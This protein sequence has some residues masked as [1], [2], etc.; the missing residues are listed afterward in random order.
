MTPEQKEPEYRIT[1]SQ[2]EIF[3]RMIPTGY[4]NVVNRVRSRPLTSAP[5]NKPQSPCLHYGV[6]YFVRKG[7]CL[8]NDGEDCDHVLPSAQDTTGQCENCKNKGKRSCMYH[9]YSNIPLSCNCKIGDMAEE[10]W[11]NLTGT[12]IDVWTPEHDEQIRQDATEKV[13]QAIQ[14]WRAN[15][16]NIHFAGDTNDGYTVVDAWKDERNFINSLIMRKHNDELY[17]DIE[18]LQIFP[19]RSIPKKESLRKKEE[20]G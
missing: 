1:E 8:L 9:G 12:F 7:I 20:P 10:A 18:G 11:R 3:E 19:F 17:P 16:E 13:I 15:I 14:S 6:C 5:Q 4:Q 2:L